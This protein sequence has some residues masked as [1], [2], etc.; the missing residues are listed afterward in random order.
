M[1][2]GAGDRARWDAIIG[3]GRPSGAS[4]LSSSGGLCGD[5]TLAAGRCRLSA[6]HSGAPACCTETMSRACFLGGDVGST[7]A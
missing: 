2:V 6:R 4:R 5:V 7:D 3:K 1:T